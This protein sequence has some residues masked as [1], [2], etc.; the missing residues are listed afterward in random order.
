MVA[1]AA[2]APAGAPAAAAQR[3]LAAEAALRGR[4][5]APPL[6]L[7]LTDCAAARALPGMRP[8]ALRALPDA[9]RAP[10]GGA[11]YSSTARPGAPLWEQVEEA[12]SGLG[13][14]A[15]AAAL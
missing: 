4:G 10:S 3:L 15:R 6:V 1:H 11:L 12:L 2:G 13:P 5:G 14:A 7:H 9:A 8:V